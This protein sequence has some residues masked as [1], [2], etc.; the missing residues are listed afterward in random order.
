NDMPE[1]SEAALEA[2][3]LHRAYVLINRLMTAEDGKADFDALQAL[4]EAHSKDFARSEAF[5]L[6]GHALNFCIRKMNKGHHEYYER[7]A[8]LY[9]QLLDGGFLLLNGLFPPQQFKNIVSLHC[10]IG[11]TA[12]AGD[13]IRR[14]AP[15]LPPK[16]REQAIL[17]NTGVLAFFQQDY[18]Q[19]IQHLKNV[20]A[21][22]RDD[23]FYGIDARV[24]L[25]RSYFEHSDA[26]SMEEYDEMHRLYDAFRL[27]VERND[28]IS[29]AHKMDYRNFIRIF[30]RMIDL[31][32]DRAGERE[33]LELLRQEILETSP[34]PNR[35]WMLEKVEAALARLS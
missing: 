20:I 28:K 22:S 8:A 7:T 21:Q 5:E 31:F 14:H 9:R 25:W 19:A 11:Q 24:Y 6:Y 35:G 1:L 10:R 33:A 4:L 13:F 27:F 26:L 32:P 17:Y 3:P 15:Q 2:Q 29:N 34:L 12:W 30:K 16:A 23:V 18:P